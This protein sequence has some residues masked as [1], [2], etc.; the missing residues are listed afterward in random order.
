MGARGRSWRQLAALVRRRGSSSADAAEPPVRATIRT[1]IMRTRQEQARVA[2]RTGSTAVRHG[3]L[4]RAIGEQRQVL[5]GALEQACQAVAAAERAAELARAD[6]G[7]AAA[8]P[9]EHTRQALLSQLDVVTAAIGQLDRLRADALLNLQQVNELL[10]H[11]NAS[12]DSA[13]RAEVVL[14][15]RLERLE[16][17]RAIAAAM[18]RA[19]RGAGE[20]PR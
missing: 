18:L 4:E 3:E 12:L 6:G 15:G 1:A 14:L 2:A 5:A 8:E 7:A 9:Y 13:L 16:R 10:Q 20:A 11:N 19:R 17:E